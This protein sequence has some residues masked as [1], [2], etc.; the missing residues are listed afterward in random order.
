MAFPEHLRDDLSGAGGNFE[1]AHEASGPGNGTL[2]GQLRRSLVPIFHRDHSGLAFTSE[3]LIV[4]ASPLFEKNCTAASQELPETYVED[5][6]VALGR[7]SR[8][9]K[10]E[11]GSHSA[12]TD[13]NSEA[14]FS[15]NTT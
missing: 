11:L 7:H 5:V 15:V 4:V 2:L 10:E 9:A 6:R 8:V 12:P 1:A 3:E 14:P 13:S